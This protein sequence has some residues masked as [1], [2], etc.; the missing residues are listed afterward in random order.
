MSE[1]TDF[2]ALPDA[3]PPT[4]DEQQQAIRDKVAAAVDAGFSEAVIADLKKKIDSAYC[5]LQDSVEWTLKQDIQANLSYYVEDCA[6][7]SIE[8]MLQGNVTEVL[9]YLHCEPGYTGR[10]Y[11]QTWPSPFEPSPMA[12]RRKLVEAFPELIE[13]QRILDLEA[14]IKHMDAA[15]AEA[16]KR[17]SKLQEEVSEYI[18]GL[19]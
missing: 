1:T 15:L 17:I 11:V 14:T 3:Q 10:D 18:R 8:A 7:R 2:L 9:R 5:S 13:Q 19:R 16:H 4:L 6:R 12:L